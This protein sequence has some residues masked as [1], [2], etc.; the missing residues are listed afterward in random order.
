[1]KVLASFSNVLGLDS[2]VVRDGSRLF[3]EVRE[4]GLLRGETWD[5]A[6]SFPATALG[7][8]EATAKMLRVALENVAPYLADE[9][10]PADLT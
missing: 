9:A 1:M 3:I 5:R 6:D 4:E 10:T 7:L 8:G 2:R